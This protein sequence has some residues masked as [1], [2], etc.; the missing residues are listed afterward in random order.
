MRERNLVPCHSNHLLIPYPEEEMEAAQ[1][2]HRL[3]MRSLGDVDETKKQ[4]ETIIED[5]RNKFK[6]SNTVSLSSLA[7]LMRI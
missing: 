5:L 2:K 1:R 3:Q 7:S 6:A 4:M